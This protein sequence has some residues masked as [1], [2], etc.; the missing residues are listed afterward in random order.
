MKKWIARMLCLI[1]AAGICL[2]GAAEEGEYNEADLA[3]YAFCVNTLSVAYGVPAFPK[4]IWIS[5]ARPSS[6]ANTTPIPSSTRI[7]INKKNNQKN[8]T[9]ERKPAPFFALSQ[10][11]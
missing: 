8:G 7:T 10:F 11:S 5:S 4:N 2:P 6:W 3:A 1:L 9:G